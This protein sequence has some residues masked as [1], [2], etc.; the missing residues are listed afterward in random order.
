[1]TDT[2]PSMFERLNHWISNSATIKLISI[3]ILILLLLIP[4]F[5]ITSLIEERERTREAAIN[6]VSN[7][8]SREQIVCGPILT[9]PYKQYRE[10][11]KGNLK[12]TTAYAHFLPE[13]LSVSGEIMPEKRHRGIYDVVVYNSQMQYKGNFL[14]PDFS[15][16]DI[17]EE[18]ILWKDA[19]VSVGISDMRG[20]Q[21]NIALQWNGSTQ[22]FNPG[23]Q[24]TLIFTGN[25]QPRPYEY[26]SYGPYDN[27]NRNFPKNIANAGVSTRVPLSGR[28]ENLSY[29]FSL[30]LNGSKYLN[31]VPLGKETTVGLTSPWQNPSFDGAFLPEERT[32]EADGFDAHW[33]V[34]HLN[35]NYPQQW[36]GAAYNVDDSVFGVNLLV[37]VDQYQKSMRSAK[38]A[39]MII[40]LTFLLF[41]FVEVLNRKRIHPFQYILVGLAICIFYTLL[42]S[43][44]E[45]TSFNFAY[46]ISSVVI[47]GMITLYAQSIFKNQLLTRILAGMLVIIYG[48]IFV[49]LQLQDFAL[50]M[51]SIGL[52]IV[53]GIVMYLSRK[54][55]WYNFKMTDTEGLNKVNL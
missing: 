52:L 5:M 18:D 16:W 13:N 19:F 27:P 25:D 11:E 8:W 21:E 7:K 23:M 51:G 49:I 36:Q 43:I 6:E 38:Y 4:T 46:I 54:V 10:D 15:E 22:T 33:K 31:F 50:L 48:F 26:D 44:S 28:E 32:V 1:M 17:A 34:L 3:G 30:D 55:D 20:I 29:N 9:V 40:A 53:L 39:V 24:A 41:F 47:I 42:L 35:R 37:P 2:T 14:R 45:H 12:E